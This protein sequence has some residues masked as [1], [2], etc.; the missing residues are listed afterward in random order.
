ME[1]FRKV[2]KK[3]YPGMLV[4]AKKVR[5]IDY[6][7]MG[8]E[9]LTYEDKLSAGFI[10]ENSEY[11]EGYYLIKFFTGEREFH[12]GSDLFERNLEL[13]LTHLKK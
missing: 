13:D 4:F 12:W 11:F 10:L 7:E 8:N 3:G 9:I 2:N 1:G 6:S 5:N